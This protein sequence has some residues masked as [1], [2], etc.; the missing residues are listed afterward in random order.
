MKKYLVAVSI[1]LVL[2]MTF[3]YASNYFFDCSYCVDNYKA[4]MDNA[5]VKDNP[6]RQRELEQDCSR[7]KAECEKG[8]KDQTRKP[9]D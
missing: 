5:K 9:N 8:C 2:T 4:C 6:S 7:R 1:I 3:V